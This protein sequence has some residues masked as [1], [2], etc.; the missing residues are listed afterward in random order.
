M[1]KVCIICFG[2]FTCNSLPISFYLYLKSASAGAPCLSIYCIS[3]CLSL[4][5]MCF[6]IFRQ[7]FLYCSL[8]FFRCSIRWKEITYCSIWHFNSLWQFMYLIYKNLV[9]FLI[10][11]FTALT[12]SFQLCCLLQRNTVFFSRVRMSYR[13]PCPS[14]VRYESFTA[15][16]KASLRSSTFSSNSGTRFVSRIYRQIVSELSPNDSATISLEVIPFNFYPS[17]SYSS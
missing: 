4:L 1:A 16:M 3:F 12:D 9:Y 5:M 15:G 2:F 10:C 8:K 7:S 14:F 11:K 17:P 6:K 13:Q